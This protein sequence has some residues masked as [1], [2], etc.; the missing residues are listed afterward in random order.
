MYQCYHFRA[1]SIHRGSTGSLPGSSWA[2]PGLYLDRPG[3]CLGQP[4]LFRR[5]LGT[6]GEAPAWTV[7]SHGLCLDGP[8]THP[9]WLV[10]N[11]GITVVLL[12]N[13]NFTPDHLSNLPGWSW[14]LPG[15]SETAA[16]LVLYY[17]CITAR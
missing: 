7:A 12:R 5:H 13:N 10:G 17:T 4:G 8:K 14:A 6:I 11:L 16:L 9:G 1:F 2:L 15:V 3:L